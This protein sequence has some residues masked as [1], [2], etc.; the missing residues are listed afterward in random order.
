M[1]SIVHKKLTIKGPY[2]KNLDASKKIT[3]LNESIAHVYTTMNIN[4][5]KV[6][7][8]ELMT[9]LELFRRMMIL[10]MVDIKCS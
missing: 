5:Y 4:F 7:M 6:K 10:V 3:A 8:T 9:T 1:D 2:D